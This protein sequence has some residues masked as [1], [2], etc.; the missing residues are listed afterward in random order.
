MN[1]FQ[2]FNRSIGV[3]LGTV[4]TLIYLKGKGILVN[5]PTVIAVNN[6]TDQL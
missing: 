3:D 5:E 2:N 6:K 4:N 1:I